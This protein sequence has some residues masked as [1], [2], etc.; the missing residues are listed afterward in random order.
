MKLN[1]IAAALSLVAATAL[2]ATSGAHF[3][4]ASASVAD[5]GALDV[6]FDEAGLGNQ[7][8]NYTLTAQATAVYACFNGG[9]KHPAASN[10]VG[11]SALSASLNNVQPKNGR[12]IAS[13]TV[14]P[15]ANTTLSCPSGQTLVLACVSYTDVLLTDTTNSVD[16][17]PTGTTNRTFVSGKGISCS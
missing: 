16:I 1:V 10:K 9:D 6:A 14:G 5:S 2:A 11:P 7:N 12:V 3:M 17:I 13:I 8:V 15:P 4:S